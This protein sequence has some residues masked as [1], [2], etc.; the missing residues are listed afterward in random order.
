MGTNDKPRN[1]TVRRGTAKR[2]DGKATADKIVE[3]AYPLL[4][5]GGAAEWSLRNVADRAGIR[6]ANLQYYFPKKR[7]FDSG[8]DGICGQALR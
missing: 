1:L 2:S 8:V 6:L 7:K 4:Q 3:A 5:T